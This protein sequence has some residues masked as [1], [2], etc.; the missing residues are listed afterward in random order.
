MQKK[1]TVLVTKSKGRMK[2]KE[3]EQKKQQ[4]SGAMNTDHGF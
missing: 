1:K 3:R 2:R 4:S